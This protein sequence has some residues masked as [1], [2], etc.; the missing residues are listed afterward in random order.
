[1]SCGKGGEVVT[2]FNKTIG[3]RGN[4]DWTDETQEIESTNDRQ[5]ACHHRKAFRHFQLGKETQLPH[6]PIIYL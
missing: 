6:A 2:F 1:M 5:I 3:V 4:Q